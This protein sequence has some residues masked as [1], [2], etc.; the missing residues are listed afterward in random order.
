M[1][2]IILEVDNAVARKWLNS[3]EQVKKKAIK[4]LE[5]VVLKEAA[6]GYGL[7]DEKLI[8]ANRKHRKRK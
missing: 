7:P 4:L 8:R 5:Q 3:P 6:A 2:R 1:D